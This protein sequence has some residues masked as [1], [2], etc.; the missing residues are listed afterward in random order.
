MKRFIERFKQ[1]PFTG[2]L[3]LVAIL[4]LVVW[5]VDMVCRCIYWNTPLEEVPEAMRFWFGRHK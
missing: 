4:V 5:A 2:I 1:D 3:F